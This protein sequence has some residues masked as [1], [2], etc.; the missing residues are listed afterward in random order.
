MLKF[1]NVTF[2]Y[3]KDSPEIL[4]N[5]NVEFPTN[6]IN[7]IMSANG[8]GKTTVLKLAS[9]I[10]S[11]TKGRIA[12]SNKMISYVFQ[13]DRLMDE[14][15]VLD[16]LLMIVTAKKP[17]YERV[18]KRHATEAII[19]M[20]DLLG[21]KEC[22]NYYPAQLSGSMKKRVAI[23]RA[24]LHPGELL[25]MDEPFN[26]LDIELKTQI[27]KMFIKLWEHDK[28]TVLFVTHSA[29]EALTLGNRIYFLG[30]KPM[31][32]MK[33]FDV[34]GSNANRDLTSDLMIKY[35]RKIFKFFFDRVE[36]EH[37]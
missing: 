21:I 22:V 20:L 10:L 36:E 9:R 28:R 14:L 32:V 23:A 2:K 29:D 35:R 1:E 25:L 31:R 3:S 37:K 26:N 4:E 11:P 18:S 5:F 19:K 15:T 17:G 7:V 30:N 13:E 6:T 8:L 34:K 12:N 33:K 27:M 24:F 16:N